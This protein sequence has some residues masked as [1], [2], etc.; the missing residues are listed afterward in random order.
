VLEESHSEAGLLEYP[1]YTRPVD[2]RGHVVPEVLAGGNHAEI[3]KW[4][5][6]QAVERTRVRRPDLPGAK[7]GAPIAINPMK[8]KG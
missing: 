6:Q 3:T 2:F 8:E 5:N 1:H 4:R 7:A